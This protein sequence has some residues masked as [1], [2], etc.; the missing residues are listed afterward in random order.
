MNKR[1]RKIAEAGIIAALYVVLTMVSAV[2]GLSTN[3]VQCRLGE[4]VCLLPVLT[5]SAIPGVTLGCLISNLMTTG[6]IFDIIIGT[7]A[8]LIGAAGA[9]LLRN[10]K[11]RPFASLPTVL[12]NA[13]AV[14][15]IIKIMGGADPLMYT[16]ITVALGE[17]LSCTVLGELLI[18]SMK[19]SGIDRLLK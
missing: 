19:R 5:T 16:G 3:A 2:F 6:S 14:P 15:I 7:F 8:T 9:Y 1:V 11:L 12:A 4:A 18:K 10:G 13:I 17:I